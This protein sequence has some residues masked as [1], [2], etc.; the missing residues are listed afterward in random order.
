MIILSLTTTI[1]F[2]FN[3]FWRCSPKTHIVVHGR[4]TNEMTRNPVFTPK[5]KTPEKGV[6]SFAWFSTPA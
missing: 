3:N 6:F 1:V 2:V 5:E 4:E